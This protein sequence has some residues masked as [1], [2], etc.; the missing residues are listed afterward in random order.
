MDVRVR[1]DGLRDHGASAVLLAADVYLHWRVQ[2]AGAVNVWGYRGPVVG[3]KQPNEIRVVVLG[4]STA[5]GTVCRGTK[6]FRSTS[7][8]C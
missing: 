3:R 5:F 4:G 7:S 8:R 1:R 6:P 2:N